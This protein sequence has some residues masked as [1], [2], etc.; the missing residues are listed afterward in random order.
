MQRSPLSPSEP[1]FQQAVKREHKK[2]SRN[3]I[4]KDAF[5]ILQQKRSLAG[6]HS[7]PRTKKSDVWDNFEYAKTFKWK[8]DKKIFQCTICYK[9]LSYSSSTSAMR[10]H[11][12]SYH[13][14]SIGAQAG[15][16]SAIGVGVQQSDAPRIDQSPSSKTAL[17]KPGLLFFSI[18]NLNTEKEPLI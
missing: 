18:K 9:V 15:S 1:R 6:T 12:N 17:D 2:E 13:W 16:G 3:Q 7:Q 10:K 4:V 14:K 8:E 11:N 5:P